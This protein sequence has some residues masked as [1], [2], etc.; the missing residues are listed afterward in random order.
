MLRLIP[1]EERVDEADPDTKM[2][3]N[4]DVGRSCQ[5]GNARRHKDA[6]HD[7][8][9]LR[10]KARD[11]IQLYKLVAGFEKLQHQQLVIENRQL[12]EA[13]LTTRIGESAVDSP[14]ARASMGFHRLSLGLRG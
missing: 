6:R 14:S 10:V 11:M 8:S 5:G 4:E 13:D 12:V 9:R 2:V 1:K 7:T 3:F